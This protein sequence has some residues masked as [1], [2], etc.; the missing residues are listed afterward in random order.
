MSLG[1]A[2]SAVFK[3]ERAFAK[4]SEQ[5]LDGR[6]VVV[7]VWRVAGVED[8]FLDEVASKV[9]VF[10]HESVVHCLWGKY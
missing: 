5:F 7:V 10:R 6:V 4:G 2:R 1:A 8:V 9:C 3:D